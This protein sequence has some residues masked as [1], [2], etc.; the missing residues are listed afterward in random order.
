VPHF[1]QIADD[2]I[3]DLEEP[4]FSRPVLKTMI[5]LLYN[6]VV[7]NVQQ[8]NQLDRAICDVSLIIKCKWPSHRV[9]WTV[10]TS[11]KY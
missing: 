2:N 4:F 6:L 9:S 10:K 3:H 1:L 7:S 5:S 8:S 11:I